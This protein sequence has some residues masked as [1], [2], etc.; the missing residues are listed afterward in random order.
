MSQF[1]IHSIIFFFNICILS[2]LLDNL[3]ENSENLNL[4]FTL[5]I[6]FCNWGMRP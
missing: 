1:P 4:S 3:G 5:V 2:I 6:K